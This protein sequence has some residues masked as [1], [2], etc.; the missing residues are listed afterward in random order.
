MKRILLFLLLIFSFASAAFADDVK[1][2]LIGTIGSEYTMYCVIGD[3]MYAVSSNS[4]SSISVLDISGGYKKIKEFSAGNIV[5][6]VDSRG[7]K[8]FVCTTSRMNVYDVSDVNNIRQLAF[9]TYPSS[10]NYARIAI[11]GDSVYLS[12]CK[13]YGGGGSVGLVT[14]SVPD[15]IFKEDAAEVLHA[16]Y[17]GGT[18]QKVDA[19]QRIYVHNGYLYAV[20]ECLPGAQNP[21]PGQFTIYNVKDLSSPEVIGKYTMSFENNKGEKKYPIVSAISALDDKGIIYVAVMDG[22]CIGSGS[23]KINGVHAFDVNAVLS[24]QSDTPEHEYLDLTAN[25]GSKR[26]SGIVAVGNYL[27]VA[28]QDSQSVCLWKRQNDEYLNKSSYI[29]IDRIGG[30]SIYGAYFNDVYEDRIFAASPGQNGMEIKISP[31]IEIQSAGLTGEATGEVSYSLH[32]ANNGFT[33]KKVSPFAAFYRGNKLVNLEK[34]EF[35]VLSGSDGAEFNLDTVG[36]KAD[37]VRCGVLMHDRCI[38]NSYMQLNTPDIENFSSEDELKAQRDENGDIII[39]GKSTLAENEKLFISIVNLSVDND[40]DRL[41][42]YRYLSECTVRENGSYSAVCTPSDGGIYRISVAG[43]EFFKTCEIKIPT[44]VIYPINSVD[45][46]GSQTDI[47]INGTN[48]SG[49]HE[50]SF[51]IDYP[52]DILSVSNDIEFGSGFSGSFDMSEKGK[53]KCTVVNGGGADDGMIIAFGAAVS[54]DAENGEYPIA[55]IQIN[56]YDSYSS[57]LAAEGNEALIKIADESEKDKL[58]NEAVSA[59]EAVEEASAYTNENYFVKSPAVYKAEEKL[60]AAIEGGIRKSRFDAAIIKRFE[61]ARKKCSAIKSE[62]DK[63][64]ALKSAEENEAAA[65]IR[66]YNDTFNI[67]ESIIKTFES[68]LDRSEVLETVR[69]ITSNIPSAY[70]E[71]FEESVAL[72]TV[73]QKVWSELKEEIVNINSVLKLNLN[74]KNIDAGFKAIARESFSDVQAVRSAFDKA[75][76]GEK[77]S[78]GSGSSGGGGSSSS[79]KKTY[80]TV[81][82]PIEPSEQIKN[83]QSTKKEIF[84]DISAVE[85]AKSA[86]EY[87]SEKKIINGV[88][89]GRFDPDREVTREEFV[90]MA[91]LAFEIE[92]GEFEAD[93]TDVDDKSW[94]TPYISAAVCS[95]CINGYPDGSFGTGRSISREEMAVL[96]K[97]AA[98]HKGITLGAEGSKEFTDFEDISLY[99]ADILKS[100]YNGGVIDGNES[101][102]FMPKMSATRAMAAKMIYNAIL[103]GEK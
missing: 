89:D 19:P 82:N 22:Q 1:M 79:G 60:D 35:S 53:I 83:S 54:E 32:A 92:D 91:V 33:D 66:K 49:V 9:Y 16:E 95:G 36:E 69:K 38:D 24:G 13:T 86:I 23:E 56:A 3:N 47:I 70:K 77:K 80:Y 15:S 101:G 90:K 45:T 59:L 93:F 61:E 99:A 57:P 40:T 55:I 31:F 63:I 34:S 8:L 37:N 6:S 94:Y 87:L 100:L 67:D 42:G 51:V 96:I 81:A 98:E 20:S 21:H 52:S 14:L 84:S 48:L 75:A 62:L 46:A 50:M 44:P 41:L 71:A 30:T 76:A 68:L 64:T 85:W 28:S 7:D 73:R 74:A 18:G 88:G 39:S 5:S 27:Y 12:L 72:E 11:E 17:C 26:V 58:Y 97:R 10:Q 78:G 2:E 4:N 43:G 65:I 103:K 102:E 29:L 25:M